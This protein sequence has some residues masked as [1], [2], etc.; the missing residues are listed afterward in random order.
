M[1]RMSR[2]AKIAAGTTALLVSAGLLAACS[3]PKTAGQKESDTRQSN[4][5]RLVAQQPA[6]TMATSPSRATINFW[7]DTWGKDPNKLAYVYLQ[8]SN[9]QLI[10]YYVFKGLPVSY[11]ASQTPTTRWVDIPNDGSDEKTQVP[12]PSIDGVFYSGGQC[13][14]YYGKDASSGSYIEFTLGNAMGVL[15]YDRPLPRQNVEPLGFATTENV[16]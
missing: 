10:G 4:Y 5:A 11:C 3:G 16:K 9:G 14:Q 2:T 12:A 13:N 1:P 15:V 8:A 6:H 7:I